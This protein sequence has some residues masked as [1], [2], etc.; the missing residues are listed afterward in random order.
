MLLLSPPHPLWHRS[1]LSKLGSGGRAPSALGRNCPSWLPDP[2]ATRHMSSSVMWRRRSRVRAR[3][4]CWTCTKCRPHRPAFRCCGCASF[5]LQTCEGLAGFDSRLTHCLQR[6]D[7]LAEL[8]ASE[9]HPFTPRP[10]GLE[11]ITGWWP[12]RSP[13]LVSRVAD[14]LQNRAPPRRLWPAQPLSGRGSAQ[15]RRAGSS[16]QT[17][18]P[19]RSAC[20]ILLLCAV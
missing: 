8:V 4:G 1:W 19:V 2:A 16:E 12:C 5:G 10:D 11:I 14:A 6:L 7:Q 13:P 17:G 15:R 20:R 3:S 18:V 9:E